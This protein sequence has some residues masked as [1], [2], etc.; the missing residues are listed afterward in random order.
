M[1]LRISGRDIAVRK[2]LYRRAIDFI[3]W[4]LT[5]LGWRVMPDWQW[6]NR[7]YAQWVYYSKHKRFPEPDCPRDMNDYIYAFKINPHS[8]LYGYFVDKELVKGYISNV[9]GEEFVVPTLG[10]FRGV[11]RLSEFNHPGPYVVKPTHMSGRILFKDNGGPLTHQELRSCGKW[12]KQSL[13]QESREANYKALEPKIIIEELVTHNG[14]YPPDLKIFVSNG[15]C[16]LLQLD[17]GRFNTHRRNLYTR[18]WKLIEDVL[19]KLPNTEEPIPPPPGLAEMIAT[20][21]KV[22]AM[23][24]FVRVDFFLVDGGYK[25]AEITF[26]PGNGGEPFIPASG[27]ERLWRELVNA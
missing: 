23:F 14:G 5:E 3:R 21:E 16:G 22:G 10:V 24:D 6:L 20:S 26:S 19:L 11:S 12:L 9:A 8:A 25:F 13:Y 2:P 17:Q 15:K 7:L 18:D 1:Y 27:G 4:R